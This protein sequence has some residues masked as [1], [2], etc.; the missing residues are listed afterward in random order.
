VQPALSIDLGTTHTVAVVRRGGQQPRTLVFD[1]TPLLPSGV[2]VDIIG[3]VH[4]GRDAQRLGAS[5]PHRYEP[6]PKRRIDDGTVLLGEIGVPVAELLAAVL[7]RVS[8][9]AAQAGVLPGSPTVLTCPADWGQPRR[10]VLRDATRRAGLGHAILVDEP[11]A[12]A[13]YCADVLGRQVPVGAALAVFDFGGGTLDVAV[14]RREPTGFRVLGT[15]GLDDL[16]GVDIDA[17]LVGHLGQLLGTVDPALWRRLSAPDDTGELRD[18]LTFWA[19]VRAAKEM[20]SRA[21]SAPVHVPGRAE[22]MHLTRDELDRVAGPLVARAVDETRRVIERVRV[23]PAALLL[24]GGTS[25]LPLVASRLHARLGI[26]PSV[27]EQPELPVAYGGL[28]V[29]LTEGPTSPVPYEPPAPL[30]PPA[31]PP[32]QPL[33]APV[34]VQS[35][36]RGR[37]VLAVTAAA[38]AVAVVATAA[39]GGLRWLGKKWDRTVDNVGSN[40]G[41]NGSGTLSRTHDVPLT[42]TGAVAVAAAAETVFYAVASPGGTELVALPAVEGNEQWRVKLPI[43]PTK[44]TLTVVGGLLVVDGDGSVLDRG[45]DVR[46]VVDL[47]TRKMVW[48][49]AWEERRDVAYVGTDVIV[50]ARQPETLIER[51]DLKNG[52]A[53]W[54]RPGPDDLLIIDEWRASAMRSWPAS[55]EPGPAELP[56]TG[57]SM[58]DTMTAGTDVVELNEEQGRGYLLDGASG[59][60]KASGALPLDDE[61]WVA[62]DGLAIGKLSDDVSAREALAAYRVSGFTRAWQFDG[63]DAGTTVERVKPCG[64][65]LVCVAVSGGDTDRVIALNTADGKEVWHRDVD[66]SDEPGWYAC[67]DRLLFGDATF[68]TVDEP[69]LLDTGGRVLHT[70]GRGTAMGVHGG[71]L[72]L[73]EVKVNGQWAVSLVD[74][75]TGRR[76]PNAEI[77]PA[78][79][80]LPLAFT[81]GG[82]TVAVITGDRHV[83]VYRADI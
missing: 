42:G 32:R 73:R 14:V 70:L 12:A 9:E 58:Y 65:H 7:R 39:T 16:G 55:A 71:R 80:D 82:G 31:F 34:T 40:L 15:G 60:P 46:A 83:A 2:Y 6:Y 68:D 29:N 18:R 52:K 27:P 75:A 51:V 76:S 33:V 11:V 77:G 5:E 8:G 3:T 20:L 1:G 4:T 69:V 19:E 30:A 78:D 25:R 21:S 13:T 23:Q 59:R 43:E 66:W 47:A 35:R 28:L 54:T 67:G 36:R 74:A 79:G 45:D 37:T 50:E 49:R 81:V 61:L 72:V 24:V 56:P 64:P 38:L 53:R 57:G 48:K 17:A 10:E 22:P 26:P 62:F 41:G 44:L 63:V